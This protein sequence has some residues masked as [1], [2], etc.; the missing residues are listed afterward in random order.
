MKTRSKQFDVDRVSFPVF[1]RGFA[2]VVEVNDESD[3][4]KSQAR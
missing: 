4:G 3:S 1:H 2:F